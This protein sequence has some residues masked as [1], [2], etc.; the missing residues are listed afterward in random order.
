[1]IKNGVYYTKEIVDNAVC[2]L[3]VKDDTIAIG[4]VDLD[5]YDFDGDWDKMALHFYSKIKHVPY[6][7]GAVPDELYFMLW[8]YENYGSVIYTGGYANLGVD[9]DCN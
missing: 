8:L 3:G 4:I 6:K 2:F 7:G 5:K 1:M 9:N